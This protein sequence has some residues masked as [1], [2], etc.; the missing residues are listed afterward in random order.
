MFWSSWQFFNILHRKIEKCGVNFVQE[1]DK[2]MV[3]VLQKTSGKPSMHEKAIQ[4]LQ[5]L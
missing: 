1:L 4:N 2:L 5:R 3:K